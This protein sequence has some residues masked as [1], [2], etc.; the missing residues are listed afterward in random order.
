MAWLKRIAGTLALAAMVLAGLVAGLFIAGCG[1]EKTP[2]PPPPAPPVEQPK[3]EPKPADKDK[4]K[5][6]VDRKEVEEGQP[7]PRNY[8]E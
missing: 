8:L 4:D 2:A 7:L 1:S 5:K 3:P 6:Q